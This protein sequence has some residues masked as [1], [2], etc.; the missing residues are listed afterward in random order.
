VTALACLIGFEA[1]LVQRD[2][3]GLAPA[4][5]AAVPAWAARALIR[6]ALAEAE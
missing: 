6:A 5:G 4:D 1:V 2:V 3:R